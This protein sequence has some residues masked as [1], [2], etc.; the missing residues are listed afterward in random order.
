MKKT[1]EKAIKVRQDYSEHDI[2]EHLQ[3]G[4]KVKHMC[5]FNQ[6]SAIYASILIVLERE[7]DT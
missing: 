7:I 6:A 5:A 4:W 3:Q 1:E 2:N